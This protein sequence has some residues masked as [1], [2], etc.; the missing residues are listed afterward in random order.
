[1][2]KGFQ[3]PKTLL[4]WFEAH[5]GTAGWAQAIVAGVAI[6]A[7]YVAATVP[8][9][10]EARRL[11]AERKSKAD[12][13]ELLLLPEVL[14]LLGEI[15]A[16]IESGDINDEP[17]RVSRTLMDRADDMYLMG[18]RGRRLLQAL[19]M[20][21]GVATQTMRFHRIC[22]DQAAPPKERLAKG[23]GLW[24]NNVATLRICVVN[25]QEVIAAINDR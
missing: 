4:L 21:N 16:S 11:E 25:L 20:L 12:G 10:A 17:I 14:T 22:N 18:D 2:F 3:F 6:V 15:E 9:R 1:M 5:P 8:V 24:R 19:G 23:Q 7:V 13:L